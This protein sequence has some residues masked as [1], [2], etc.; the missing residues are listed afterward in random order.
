MKRTALFLVL[1]A[2][3]VG[4]GAQVPAPAGKTKNVIL[5][6]PDGMGGA[7]VTLARFYAGQ[8]LA[9]DELA[10]GTMSTWSS[11]GTVAD[12]APAGSALAT[13]WKSQ[14]GNVATLGKVY[15]L[16]GVRSPGE[17]RFQA[18]VATVLEAARL[19]GRSTGLVS[20]SE[21]MHAT[22]ADFSAHDSSRSS[23]DNLAEQIAYNGLSVV[24]GG[25]TK[26]LTAAGRKDGEDLGAIFGE[27]GFV[28]VGNT[29]EL[30]AAQGP[31]IVGTFGKDADSTALSY[32]LDRDP[33]QEPSLAEM[34]S[35]AIDVLSKNN[36]GFFLMVEGSKIDWAAHA[37]DPIAIVTDILAFDRAVKVALDFAKKDKNTIVFAVTDHGNSGIS[38]G[39][40]SIS[41]GYDKT[42][43]TTFIDPLKRAK[44]TGEGFE[45]KLPADKATR[46]DRGAVI[47]QAAGQWLGL[48]DL[49]DAEVESIAQAKSG[50]MNYAVGPMIAQRA[51]IGF[52]TGGH[53]GEDVTYYVYDPSPARLR[54]YIDN[55]D[56]ALYLA[57]SLG[58]N[59]DKA[60]ERLFVEARPAF[61]ARGATV[62]EDLSDTENPVLVATSKDGKTVVQVPRNKSYALVNG[63][64]V[65][66]EG[67]AVLNGGRWFVAQNL[68]DLVR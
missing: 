43:Y 29:A 13:G 58:L 19:S 14:T 3:T 20:T 39:D 63:K 22:P 17:A 51:K 47:R 64:K 15:S 11:D 2:L 27:Q 28:R 6:I 44:V 62:T 10:A 4:L 54:G 50:S 1:V 53:T 65:A 41:S 60:T 32:D 45:S 37:N 23:Y 12:S 49:T 33:T 18:P 67:V 24:L 56:V 55:T 35:K 31:K 48:T 26:Y 61:E 21:F 57:A 42:N 5:L 46:A 7:G 66:S 59:L 8:K 34:T 52:T 68:I 36:K 38:V 25:G 16:P 9:L 40:R 30:K